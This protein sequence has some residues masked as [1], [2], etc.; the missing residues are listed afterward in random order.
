MEVHSSNTISRAL[1]T[2]A[3]EANPGTFWGLFWLLLMAKKTSQAVKIICL[4]KKLGVHQTLEVRVIFYEKV[5]V[6]KI[7]NHSIKAQPKVRL[8][9]PS[10]LH[11]DRNRGN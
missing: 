5:F 3:M 2:V 1:A 6:A 4:S 11:L 8:L 9:R 7:Q 10:W